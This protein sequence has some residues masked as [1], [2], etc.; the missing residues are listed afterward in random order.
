[1]T[2]NL[3]TSDSELQAPSVECR[4]SDNY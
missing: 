3:N 1:M 4:W 2:I